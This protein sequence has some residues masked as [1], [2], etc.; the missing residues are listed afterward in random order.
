MKPSAGNSELATE[1]NNHFGI[2]C[3]KEWRGETFAHTDDAPNECFRKYTRAEDSYR[4]H[5]EYLKN[6]Q[7]YAQLFQLSQTDYAGWCVGLKKCGYATNPKY[8]QLLIRTI[9]EFELQKFTFMALEESEEAGGQMYASAGGIIPENDAAPEARISVSENEIPDEPVVFSYGQL[10]TING[11]KAFYAK[12]GTM[13][14][15]QAVKYEIRYARLLEINDLPDAP[16]EADM[17]IY[18]D[19]KRSKGLNPHHVVKP[20]ETVLQIAQKEGIQLKYLLAL[21]FI[22]DNEQPVEGAT[23]QLQQPAENKPEVYVNNTNKFMETDIASN[24]RN[25][26]EYISKSEI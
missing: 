11:L 14:L 4:D 9:E 16:L 20:G 26:S 6:S 2:K 23:L 3:K 17:F 7:R 15:N 24:K 10:I 13:L 1:A 22:G 12:K 25:E 5:S 18:L 21:N 8:A 19:K